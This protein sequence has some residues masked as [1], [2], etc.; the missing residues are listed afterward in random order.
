[1]GNNRTSYR[2][3]WHLLL[4]AVLITTLLPG[5]AAPAAAAPAAAP[6]L[7]TNTLRA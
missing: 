1:M 3:G 6:L 5:L 7:Q 4:L 2:T